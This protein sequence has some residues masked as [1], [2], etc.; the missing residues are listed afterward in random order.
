MWWLTTTHE[1]R[2]PTIH[3]LDLD[4]RNVLHFLKLNAVHQEIFLHLIINILHYDMLFSDLNAELK[5][6][7]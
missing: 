4:H 7:L 3:K 2:P 6:F 5:D 1:F